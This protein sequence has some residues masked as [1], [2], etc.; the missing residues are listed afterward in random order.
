VRL[1]SRSWARKLGVL[2][3]PLKLP[4]P[5]DRSV[6]RVASG[7]TRALL[8]AA[9][10]AIS[11]APATYSA[12]PSTLELVQS[13][14]IPPR[15]PVLLHSRLSG[16]DPASIPPIVN[17][18]LPVQEP[19][20]VETF[21]VGNQVTRDYRQADAVLRHVSAHAYWYVEQGRVVDSD[22]LRRSADWFE[23]HTY[24]TVRRLFG[25]EWFPGV[26]ND[27]RITVLMARVPGVGAY[28]SSWDEYP[29]TVYVHS[30]QREM[31][32]MNLDSIRPG[33]ADFDGVLAHEFQ[34]MVHWYGNANDE[35]WVDEGSAELATNLVMGD[36]P[37]SASAYQSQ[38]DTQLT[39]W[40]DQPGAVS[41]HYDAAYLFM[42]YFVDRY[43]G[44]ELLYELIAQ[45]A[46]GSDL[47]DHYL[48]SVGRAE[49]F[50]EVFG[51]WTV[52]NYVDDPGVADGRFNQPSV[53]VRMRESA[54]VHVG[55]SPLEAQVHQFGVD[56]VELT[57]DGSD[58]QFTIDAQ[59]TV[60]LVG[61]TPTSGS[62]MWWTNRADGMD[63]TLT[64]E[65]DLSGLQ[66]ATLQFKTWY[67]IELD[68]DYLYVM[69][70]D[71]GGT[72][73]AALQ[74]PRMSTT[75]PT[76]NAIGPGYTG[77][78][79]GGGSPV[80]VDEAVDLAAYA[81]KKILVRFEYVT[82]QA[83]NASGA[84]IDDIQVPELGFADDAE[85]DTGWIS[86]GF[87]RS[88]NQIPGSY[89]IRLI[90]YTDGGTQ[91]EPVHVDANGHGALRIA[92]LG[93]TTSR[94]VAVVAA[95]AP[96]TLEVAR[97]RIELKP[98]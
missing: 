2:L 21:W 14:A 45:D 94:A 35:T 39:A 16:V 37:L 79:G 26:D 60:G 18:D 57:G 75:N 50:A 40:S 58:V 11:V 22:P 77:T 20:H 27:P 64:R 97:Y 70:S 8:A 48:E 95:T 9:L 69:A 85:R 43:G 24:P 7:S 54:S 98:A 5:L 29:S 30:N 19:G 56:Y 82:D 28:F 15:D 89:Q 4:T 6:E 84:V 68:Y 1:S 17:E 80:W 73:W 65:I 88:D 91:V 25:S 3:A 61:A 10:L 44:P 93:G 63:S 78:S 71:D 67:E 34:H 41:P 96:R 42:R 23:E 33:S 62:Q 52:A 90:T 76:G 13:T 81:G 59:P 86:H 74:G 87:I 32:H 51:D 92:G 46:R 36:A 72:T 49:R 38:P 53:D 55:D 66:S 83:F 31:V 12:D 47:F